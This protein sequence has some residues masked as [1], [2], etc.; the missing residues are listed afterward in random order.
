MRIKS[1]NVKYIIY[2]IL[3]LTLKMTIIT[4]LHKKKKKKCFGYC[5]SISTK[6]SNVSS[7]Y[8][9]KNRLFFIAPQVRLTSER[10]A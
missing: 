10:D 1:D 5:K 2:V 9:V 7:R 4:C 8:D 6:I 3:N